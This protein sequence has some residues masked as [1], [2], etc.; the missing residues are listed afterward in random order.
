MGTAL[1][2]RA[3]T[4]VSGCLLV[5]G[6]VSAQTQASEGKLTV[7]QPEGIAFEQVTQAI[8]DDMSEELDIE[9]VIIDNNINAQ[10]LKSAIDKTTPDAIVLL[11]NSA[12]NAFV[13]LKAEQTSTP[14]ALVT[15]ALFVE[16]SLGDTDGI[17]AI[18]YEVPLV[19]SLVNTRNAIEQPLKRVGVLYREQLANQMLEQA[20]YC[21]AE[22]I[23]LVMEALPTSSIN[24]DKKVV[25][26]LKRLVRQDVDGYIL[27]NDNGLLTATTMK[28]AWLPILGRQNKP[29]VVGLDALLD[30]ALNVGSISVAPDH[31]GLGLQAASSLWDLLDNDWEIEEVEILQP[32]SVQKNVNPTVLSEKGIALREGAVDSFDA[33][34]N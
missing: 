19:T 16:Q 5:M 28:K 34:V 23:E 18:R 32:L 30:T 29:I 22:N 2:Q 8:V 21:K 27:L 25:K 33:T 14:P 26:A 13:K 17:I 12:L 7:F 15:A 10:T 3:I 11:G 4:I 24:M 6:L 9:T 20:K 1:I 31:Y